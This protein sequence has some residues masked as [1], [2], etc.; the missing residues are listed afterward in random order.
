VIRLRSF[1]ALFACLAV[2]AS[3]FVSVTALAMPMGASSAPCSHCPD[4]DGAPCPMPAAACVH[5]PATPVPTLASTAIDLP[6]MDFSDVH[7]PLPAARLSGLSQ[8]PDPFP[9]K[10]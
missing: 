1:A 9:P 7:W 5:A 8:P 2:L 10:A 4:C 3:G 6:A